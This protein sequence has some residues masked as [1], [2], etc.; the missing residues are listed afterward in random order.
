MCVCVLALVEE[1]LVVEGMWAAA[2]LPLVRCVCVCV[3]EVV[4]LVVEV[5]VVAPAGP[6]AAGG[7]IF[8]LEA[9]CVCVC[10]CVNV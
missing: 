8:S 2:A 7:D 4:L 5:A 3:A 1:G 9:G 10:V 6:M